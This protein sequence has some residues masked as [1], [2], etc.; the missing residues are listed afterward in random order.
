MTLQNGLGSSGGS[1]NVRAG[2]K[3]NL[4]QVTLSGNSAELGGAFS[5]SYSATTTI[6]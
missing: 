1:V 6:S 5:I 2:S 3:L 4:D